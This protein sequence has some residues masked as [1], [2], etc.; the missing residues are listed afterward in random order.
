V[1]I[2]NAVIIPG[3]VLSCLTLLGGLVIALLGFLK[4]RAA[5][6]WHLQIPATLLFVIL[7]GATRLMYWIILEFFQVSFVDDNTQTRMFLGG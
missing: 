7:L 3:I 4:W 6:F 1:F 5:L 2:S